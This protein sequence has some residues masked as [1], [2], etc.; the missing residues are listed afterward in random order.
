MSRVVAW[1]PVRDCCAAWVF[2]IDDALVGRV[3][4]DVVGNERTEVRDAPSCGHGI[5]EGCL[6]ELVRDALA[7]VSFVDF[8]V[9]EYDALL[10]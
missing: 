10:A 5:V 6:N 1:G 2:S 8:G 3:V 4:G 9:R 7:A